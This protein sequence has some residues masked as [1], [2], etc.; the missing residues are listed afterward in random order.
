MEMID[1]AVVTGQTYARASEIADL[2]TG[3]CADAVEGETCAW[4][5]VSPFPS[6]HNKP[7]ELPELASLRATD[8]EEVP[9][10]TLRDWTRRRDRL[11]ANRRERDA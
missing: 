5:N 8:W 7:A 6:M 10:E 4:R 11:I 2:A 1:R 9:E 3:I